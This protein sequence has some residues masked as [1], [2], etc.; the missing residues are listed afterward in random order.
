MLWEGS[1][2][3]S[4]SG[5]NDLVKHLVLLSQVLAFITIPHASLGG[6]P[7]LAKF[8]PLCILLV[9]DGVHLAAEL[10]QAPLALALIVSGL[11]ACFAASLRRQDAREVERFRILQRSVC[12]KFSLSLD[13]EYTIGGRA[14]VQIFARTWFHS[15]KCHF[16]DCLRCDAREVCVVISAAGLRRLLGCAPLDGGLALH[17]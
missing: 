16:L 11:H 7:L 5:L 17:L 13:L 2:C 4:Q 12:R 9:I 6:N 15:F 10:V 14:H 8:A 1:L 3:Q